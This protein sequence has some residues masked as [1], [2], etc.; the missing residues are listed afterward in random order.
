MQRISLRM[1]LGSALVV[2][3]LIFL[4]SSSS[5]FEFILRKALVL[6]PSSLLFEIWRAPPF[7]IDVKV[8]VFNLTNPHQFL[9]EDFKPQFEELGPYIL[10]ERD[11]KVNIV[12]NDNYTVT[13]EI[14]RTYYYDEEKSNG[15][16]EDYITALNTASLSASYGSRH[17]SL[18]STFPLSMAIR[19]LGKSVLMRKSFRELFIEGYFDP[20][21]TMAYVVPGMKGKGQLKDK[22]GLLYERNAS[23]YFDGVIN[24]GTGVDDISKLGTVF[25]WNYQ[26]RTPTFE[27]K[28]GEVYGA[29]AELF[30][31]SSSRGTTLSFFV[32][33]V[34][35][36]VTM[37][38]LDDRYIQ[39]IFGHRYFLG[40]KT[41]D[42]GS[43][44]PE[45]W[46]NCGGE[47]L[48]RGVINASSCLRDLPM[49]FSFPH[50]LF[51]DPYYRERVKG[52]APPDLDEH[53]LHMTVEPTTGIPLEAFFRLQMNL[54][55]RDNPK[56]SLFRDVPTIM[57]PYFWI[58]KKLALPPNM[59]TLLK[60]I[61]SI[62]TIIICFAIALILLGLI[63][64]TLAVLPWF[65]SNKYKDEN[66]ML[67][68]RK[69]AKEIFCNKQLQPEEAELLNL[70]T[71]GKFTNEE[72]SK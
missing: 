72:R 55:L 63:I 11:E 1:W 34:C 64:L 65:R 13:Y 24:L 31:P 35:R 20:L 56:I 28:C 70:V 7:N 27:G 39:G 59:I 62:P 14:L 22:I 17:W 18:F 54:L 5:L 12:W 40:E 67:Q 21:L 52:I 69:A 25:N 45:N 46:C 58:E 15:S 16:M 71:N 30:A 36:S 26:N 50:F 68:N 2:T 41:V 66:R 32:P 33:E 47:C 42:N 19:I 8:V 60:W 3:G 23:T 51:G 6:S 53:L 37:E 48:P 29:T 49:F 4:C 43:L 61:L 38:Y 57:F 9:E 10:Y 44:Y